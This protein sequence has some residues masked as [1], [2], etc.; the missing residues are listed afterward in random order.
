MFLIQSIEYKW[1]KSKRGS[2]FAS[3][4]SL[5]PDKL[6]LD[7]IA[8]NENGI[9]LDNKGTFLNH[10]ANVVSCDRFNIQC[11][12][13]SDVLTVELLGIQPAY[14]YPPSITVYKDEWIQLKY[15]FREVDGNHSAWFFGVR[16]INV[17]RFSDFKSDIFLTKN[18]KRVYDFQRNLYRI[19]K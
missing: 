11:N 14:G 16:I 5:L 6:P 18:P 8:E 4:R 17:G 19:S 2:Q 3:E 9:V 7:S 15:N 10:S 13:S 12:V 1:E